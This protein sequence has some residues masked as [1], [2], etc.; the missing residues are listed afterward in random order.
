M[1]D[2]KSR[3]LLEEINELETQKKLLE[4][5][6]AELE[7]IMCIILSIEPMEKV[8][9]RLRY[10]QNEICEEIGIYEQMHLALLQ[11]LQSYIKCED[12][13]IDECEGNRYVYR[14]VN[15]ELF[16]IPHRI[17]FI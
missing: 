14:L 1:F 8:M 10:I 3:A 15:A 17:S 9:G 13:I 4:E 16:Q 11:I 5:T 7:E 12:M 2:V 6:I